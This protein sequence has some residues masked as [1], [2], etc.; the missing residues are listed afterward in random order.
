MEQLIFEYNKKYGLYHL[1][2][3]SD[4]AISHL[5]Y[6]LTSDVRCSSIDFF[7]Q[8]LNNPAKLESGGNY[9]TVIK[10]GNKINIYFEYD[11]FE[12]EEEADSFETTIEQLN[13]ILDRWK[14]VCEKKPKKVI[15]TRDNDKVTVKLQD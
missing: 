13:Y 1:R 3:S 2:E 15:I 6:F 5:A 11:Y 8:W 7:K 4:L 12:L 14:E 10:N 9:S